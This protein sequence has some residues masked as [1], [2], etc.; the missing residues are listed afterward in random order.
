MLQQPLDQGSRTSNSGAHPDAQGREGCDFASEEDKQAY[1][2][3]E[4]YEYYDEDDYYEDEDDDL[5]DVYGDFSVNTKSPPRAKPKLTAGN[6][7][8]RSL[9]NSISQ[10]HQHQPDS[11]NIRPIP[12][13][14]LHQIFSYVDHPTLYRGISRVSRQF[15]AIAKHH[16]ELVGIWTLK[17]QKEEDDL[18]EKLRSG[19]VNVLKVQSSNGQAK[20]T[21]RLKPYDRWHWAWQRFVGF[22]TDPIYN[23]RTLPDTSDS[24]VHLSDLTAAISTRAR[25]PKQPCLLNRVK[26]VILDNAALP[27][28]L[29]HLHRIHT[30]EFNIKGAKYDLALQ[31][32]LKTCSNLDTLTIHGHSCARNF[33][34]WNKDTDTDTEAW[35]NSHIT[36][37]SITEVT[38]S[39]ETME[40]FLGACPRL[41]FF[42]ATDVHIRSAGVTSSDPPLAYNVPSL[43]IEPLY[44]QAAFLCP[45]LRDFSLTLK[46]PFRNCFDEQLALTA[47]LFPYTQHLDVTLSL[48]KDW[49]AD[50]ITCSFLAQLNSIAFVGK[51]AC[52]EDMDS[53]LRHCRRLTC[54][55]APEI[56]YTRHPQKTPPN[57]DKGVR[58]ALAVAEQRRHTF[59][60]PQERKDYHWRHQIP[61]ARDHHQ[62]LLQ[63]VEKKLVR[64]EIM[65]RRHQ[66]L[67]SS[68]RCP[69][70]R[71]LELRIGTAKQEVSA[72]GY[73]DVF[74][75][76]GHA[77]PNLDQLTLHL[78]ALWVGQEIQIEHTTRELRTMTF[79]NNFKGQ[80]S[81]YTRSWHEDVKTKVW[82]ESPNALRMLGRLSR[83]ERLIVYV[84][85]VPGVL[86]PS[87]FAFLRGAGY[88]GRE[89]DG[90][91][92]PQF[93]PRLQSIVISSSMTIAFGKTREELFRERQFVNALKT[94]RP[95]VTVSFN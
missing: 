63:R 94:M 85:K 17:T 67:A 21:G 82:Q 71:V 79:E 49:S 41:T 77:F 39:Q 59:S 26:K 18:L 28:L 31:P 53:L 11:T 6:K 73:E 90:V 14:I 72:E 20:T 80:L 38:F 62:K 9:S 65:S 95:E 47:E 33:I 37:F 1:G 75:F 61:I 44:R 43:P 42:K 7:P 54:L 24:D 69:R 81:S 83:L 34:C 55:S 25:D 19:A 8:I 66:H 48:T 91:A 23:N 92:E 60:T 56:S 4:D 10:N 2:E 58:A 52:N 57:V 27:D 45:R 3:E 64:E 68:W 22:I 78:D 15:N 70:L 13:E 87:H 16:I 46:H 35:I 29:P 93:C 30:L 36:H 5:D 40:E 74:R 88:R 32:I 76:L 50:P 51:E 89:Q 84:N 12:P 86:C